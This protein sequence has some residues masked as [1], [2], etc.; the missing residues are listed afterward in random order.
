MSAGR[1]PNAETPFPAHF[2]FGAKSDR[3][4][5]SE[6]FAQFRTCLPS[7]HWMCNGPTVDNEHPPSLF[8]HASRLSPSCVGCRNVGK[9]LKPNLGFALDAAVR[10]GAELRPSVSGAAIPVN[11]RAATLIS[12]RN[13]DLA[14]FPTIVRR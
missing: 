10:R 8:P 9:S 5:P 3:F 2:V 6:I 12:G 14:R 11:I 1:K 4:S 13:L 7:G